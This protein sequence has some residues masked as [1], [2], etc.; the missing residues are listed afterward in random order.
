MDEIKENNI[1]TDY[2]ITNEN[3]FIKY[4]NQFSSNKGIK[5]EEQMLIFVI[6]PTNDNI[7]NLIFINSMMNIPM[8][9]ID[10]NII[11]IPEETTKIIEYMIEM[12][13]LNAFGIF[14]FS[15]D[16]MPID[17]DLFSLDNDESFRE[18][19]IDK[20]NS[21]IEKL[22]DIMLKFEVAFGKV[23]HK[24]IKGNNAKLFCDLLLNKEEEHNIKS[25]DEI[26]G[27]IVFDRSV[28]FITPFISNLT[29]EGLVDEYFGINKGYIKVKRKSFKANFSNEDKK[30]RPEADMSY[31]LISD[32]N[33]FYCDLRCFHYLTVTK[34]LMS[35]SEHI[36]YLRDNKNNLKSTSEINAALVDLNKLIDSNSFLN[37]NMEMINQ[38]FK[39]INDEDYQ[40]KEFSI[41]KGTSQTNSETFYDDYIIDKKDMHKILNLM[42]LESL[43]GSGISNYEKFKKDILAVYGYQNLFLFRNLEKL[44]WLKEK[45]KLSLKKLF[46]SNYEQINEKLH[47][48]NEDFVLG[49]TDD[50]SYVHQG[51]CPISLRL[52]EK[53]GEGGWSEIKDV[54]QLIP[55]VTHYP[56]NEYEI[57]KPREDLNTIFLVFLGGVTYT[58]IE[59]VRYLNRKYK[60]IYDNSSEENKTRKQFIIITTQ[61]LSSKKLLSSLGKDFGSVY[62]IKKFYND[63]NKEVKK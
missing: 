33:K 50:L 36:K 14:N 48:Y 9:T 51:Y 46:K 25:T 22:A 1:K 40:T 63:I 26:F 19:Y 21:S 49:Q 55:G 37:D 15:I 10:I 18:I 20:N 34:Y 23:K 45:D 28:D 17:Y 24:Y 12:N 41:L 7:N 3:D 38:I 13:H 5:L 16:I 31:P 29:F 57:S 8:K 27:T 54:F 4:T 58:E 47:L 43:T 59:G 6:E 52:I 53:V 56:S 60:Q 30:I 32:M 39:I 11:F 62:T 35:I 44:E 42:I 2:V 61:I